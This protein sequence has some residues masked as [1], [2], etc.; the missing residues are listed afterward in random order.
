MIELDTLSLFIPVAFAAVASPGQDFVFILGASLGK[1]KWNGVYSAL[2]IGLG[3]FM[4]ALLAA[5]GISALFQQSPLAFN[6]FKYAGASY[7]CY[8]GLMGLK[9]THQKLRLSGSTETSYLKFFK[10]GLITNVLNPK[11]GIFFLAFLPSF[12][13]EAKG[14]VDQQILL[15]GGL[16]T[17]IA[18]LFFIVLA[19][20]VYKVKHF[21]EENDR[22]LELQEK[23]TAYLFI[24]LGLSI[25]VY[26]CVQYVF[27]ASVPAENVFK[28]LFG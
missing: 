2:G 9:A 13:D 6:I 25:P 19:L 21:V 26:E 8:I 20:S 15:L 27:S 5:F 24:L 10:M 17:L 7:L 16:M 4:W 22:F 23:V 1:D 11:C 14:H 3:N 18:I 12:V 28:L